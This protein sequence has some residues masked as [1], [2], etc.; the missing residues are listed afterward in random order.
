LLGKENENVVKND[1]SDYIQFTNVEEECVYCSFSL[2]N[3]I[4]LNLR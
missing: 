2:F 3:L 4:I 1:L